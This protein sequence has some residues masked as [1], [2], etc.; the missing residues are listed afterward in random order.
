MNLILNEKEYFKK[1]VEKITIS[2]EDKKFGKMGKKLDY[3][4]E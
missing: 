4:E 1:N 2:L 3:S